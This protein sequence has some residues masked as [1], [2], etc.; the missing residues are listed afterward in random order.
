MVNRTTF[1][2]SVIKKKIP[3]KKKHNLVSNSKEY[4]RRTCIDA[5]INLSVGRPCYIG[6][7]ETQ[8]YNILNYATIHLYYLV[9]AVRSWIHLQYPGLHANLTTGRQCG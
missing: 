7:Y 2:K 8:E 4:L 1:V 3:E 5:A 6:W 9:H